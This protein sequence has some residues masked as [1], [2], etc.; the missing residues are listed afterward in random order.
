MEM[1]KAYDVKV[2]MA[3]LKS[4]GLDLAEE[5]LM[6]VLEESSEWFEVSAKLSKT[7]YDDMALIVMPQIKKIAAEQID[8]IDGKVG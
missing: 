5:A 6:I 1:E 4:R 7:P 2:L 8:K 3:A